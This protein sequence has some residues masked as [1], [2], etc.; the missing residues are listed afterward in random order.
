MKTNIHIVPDDKTSTCIQRAT[1]CC[2]GYHQ[3]IAG[4]LLKSPE[5]SLW[6][7]SNPSFDIDETETI[8][9]MSD[10]HFQAFLEF[11]KTT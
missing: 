8:D 7:K 2:D 9:A 11:C 10:N 1:D 5:W 3:T 4:A 6:K